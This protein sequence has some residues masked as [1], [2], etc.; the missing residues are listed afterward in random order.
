[1][2]LVVQASKDLVFISLLY[3]RNNTVYGYGG[4]RVITESR[5][6]V[7]NEISQRAISTLNA[8]ESP[9]P[10]QFEAFDVFEKGYPFLRMPVAQFH[11]LPSA[12]G[13]AVRR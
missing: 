10:H 13:R 1:M 7:C 9:Y 8:S 5:F 2:V 4:W 11:L 12:A 3:V 6:V